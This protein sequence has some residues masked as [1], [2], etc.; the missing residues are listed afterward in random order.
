MIGLQIAMLCVNGALAN[1]ASG[2]WG[3]AYFIFLAAFTLILG[4]VFFLDNK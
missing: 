1:V 2:I 4:K 3:G